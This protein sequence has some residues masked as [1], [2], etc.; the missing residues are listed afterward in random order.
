M[1]YLVGYIF[2]TAI[3]KYTVPQQ[4]A[5]IMQCGAYLLIADAA[6]QV[7]A[8]LLYIL[9]MIQRQRQYGSLL[10]VDLYQCRNAQR[11]GI[12]VLRLI[13][14][15]RRCFYGIVLLY[16]VYALY[17]AFC[18]HLV[19]QFFRH[20]H[21]PVRC[22][23]DRFHFFFGGKQRFCGHYLFK[24]VEIPHSFFLAVTYSM[25]GQQLLIIIKSGHEY[26]PLRQHTDHRFHRWHLFRI[27]LYIIYLLV[28]SC[29]LCHTDLH[30]LSLLN[31]NKGSNII[32]VLIAG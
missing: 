2:S 17:P 6:L 3:I 14:G 16:K 30:K 4:L 27:L 5:V 23:E 24:K 13:I 19:I 7:Q 8:L 32:K 20:Y 11:H 22:Y 10:K 26:R 28:N 15:H 18:G 31:F 12:Q 1:L 21:I 29:Q 25:Y 9:E